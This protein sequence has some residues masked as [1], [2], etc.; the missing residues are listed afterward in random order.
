MKER[1]ATGV[2]EGVDGSS[3]PSSAALGRPIRSA[4]AA[5]RAFVGLGF[6]EL[7]IFVKGDRPIDRAERTRASVAMLD[8]EL[9]VEQSPPQHHL[10]SGKIGGDLIGDALDGHAGVDADL[11][12]LRLSG[13]RAE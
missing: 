3:P 9:L 1:L 10:F 12:P 2:A 8:V 5:T 4:R 6:L 11:A 13:E 7:P